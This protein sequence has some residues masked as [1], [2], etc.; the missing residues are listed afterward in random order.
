M[1]FLKIAQQ[2]VY[3]I[4]RR[5]DMA[6]RMQKIHR[7]NAG[8]QRFQNAIDRR[9]FLSAARMQAM[10]R[11]LRGRRLARLQKRFVEEKREI[12]RLKALEE[13]MQSEGA[14]KIQAIARRR[15]ATGRVSILREVRIARCVLKMQSVLRG[16]LGRE[17]ARRRKE[18]LEE[19]ERELE[20]ARLE[21]EQE[22][23]E[24]ERKEIIKREKE[25]MAARLKEMEER[26]KEK[27][28][29]RKR[30]E[31]RKLVEAEEEEEERQE[32]ERLK[33][34]ADSKREVEEKEGKDG[35]F[36][37]DNG[38]EGLYDLGDL[39]EGMEEQGEFEDYQGE[40]GL[41]DLDFEDGD[42]GEENLDDLRA[43]ATDIVDDDFEEDD[44][45]ENAN[46]LLEIEIPQPAEPPNFEDNDFDTDAKEDLND[47]L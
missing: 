32:Q 3:I 34:L 8:R 42:K 29:E 12:A 38:A 9:I 37:D 35:D 24:E 27:E 23:E 33:K 25:E 36:E 15:Q 7:G 16:R 44:G 14:T 28:K 43:P 47:L 26:A 40:E 22:R 4:Q 10:I 31:L 19:E 18:L 45:K 2:Q 30:D 6:T 17:R 20:E 41:D 46:N 13:K 5:N 1:N 39:D 21:A 11:A